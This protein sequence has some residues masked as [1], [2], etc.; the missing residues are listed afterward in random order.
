MIL[1][2]CLNYSELHRLHSAILASVSSVASLGDCGL[3]NFVGHD[4]AALQGVIVEKPFGHDL[5]SA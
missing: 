1:V 4:F 2:A 3:W 5:Q